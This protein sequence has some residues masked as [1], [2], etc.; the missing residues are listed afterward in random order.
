MT[1]RRRGRTRRTRSRAGTTAR[2]AVVAGLV[3]VA[4]SVLAPAA[5]ANY[6]RLEAA[7]GCDRVVTWRASASVEGD[8]D[9]RTN[10]RVVV[11]FRAAG[12]GA[13]WRPAGPE[14][15]FDPTND[16]AFGGTVELADG[17]DAIELRVMPLVSW[18]PDRDGDDP[19][20]PR[21]ATARVP[22]G[23]AAA[24]L[25]ARQS[26]DCAAGA[27]TV[28]TRN[29]GDQPVRAQVLV[30]D[31]AVRT[32]DVAPQGQQ[33][34][35]VPVLAGRAT[36]VAVRAGDFIVSDQVQAADCAPGGPRA[37]V[38]ERCGAPMGRLVVLATGAGE[39]MRT[40]VTV[41]GSTVVDTDVA[42]GSVLQRT[43]DV[44]D[45]ALPVEVRLDDRVGAAGIT[46]GCDGPVSG[47]LSCETTA[48]LPACDLSATR[49]AEVEAPPPPP[50]PLQVDGGGAL[51]S[52][53]PAQ[54]AIALGLGGVL[55]LGGGATLALRDRRRPVPSVLAGVLAPYRQRWWDDT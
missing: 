21:F 31:V 33:E 8:D 37:V 26:L 20:E 27:V 35:I 6:A 38:L 55:L 11:E 54:R 44:P 5:G 12:S 19:G 28:S 23:C 22:D 36:Q 39:P 25:V 50:P 13:P 32:L 47:L 40:E 45:Q 34:L 43:L 1:G 16:F 3:L 18:G 42:A 48:G 10:E 14:G 49:P 51:P 29:V 41:R 4:L 46:G 7:A 30:D 17:V 24:P 53:G 9:E 52:T 2:V 15:A